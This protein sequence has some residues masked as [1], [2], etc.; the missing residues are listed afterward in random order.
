MT[1]RR[2][3]LRGAGV[4]LAGGTAGCFGIFG[5]AGSGNDG[6][7]N[8]QQRRGDGESGSKT[9]TAS[10]VT[11]KL[12]RVGKHIALAADRLSAEMDSFSGAGIG[13]EFDE[14]QVQS[15]LDDATSVLSGI[16]DPTPEQARQIAAY[17]DLI[18][19]IR[20]LVTGMDNIAQLLNA[21]ERS[22]SRMEDTR[23]ESALSALSKTDQYLDE[24]SSAFTTAKTRIEAVDTGAFSGLSA[25]DLQ[26]I[27]DGA[28]RIQVA[29]SPIRSYLA[30]YKSLLRGFVAF[31]DAGELY[32]N[33]QYASAQQSYQDAQAQ[34]QTA[35]TQ[36]ETT[37]EMPFEGVESSTGTL[38]CSARSLAES[39]GL[40]AQA[41]G[42]A[43]RGETE[44]EG[45]LVTRAKQAA[46]Q[47]DGGV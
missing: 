29:I 19:G 18:A 22:Q 33:T 36:F 38:V 10:S 16:S 9:P 44:T 7:G 30:G 47:C 42:A 43:Q 31:V 12:V 21:I 4:A 27:I 8:G 17:R 25:S 28:D 20:S 35:R 3:V 45:R 14:E 5:S 34:F 6:R 11:E 26:P 1:S 39:A 24:A 23:P 13:V 40:W 15:P 32:S 41:A 46:N 2:H 37:G